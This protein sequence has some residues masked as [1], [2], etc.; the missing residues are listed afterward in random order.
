MDELIGTV[1]SPLNDDSR[2]NN[3][4]NINNNNDND[5]DRDNNVYTAVT[6]RIVESKKVLHH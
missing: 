2:D 4:N 3:I 1:I 6:K 5:N